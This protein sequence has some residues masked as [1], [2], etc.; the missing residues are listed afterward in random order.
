VCGEPAS[1]DTIRPDAVDDLLRQWKEHAPRPEPT[2][3]RGSQAE[4]S[5]FNPEYSPEPPQWPTT[6]FRAIGVR[7]RRSV[8][9]PFTSHPDPSRPRPSPS[10]TRELHDPG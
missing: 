8:S 10:S 5:S 2:A 1:S 6:A 7:L 4:G 9:T 3:K